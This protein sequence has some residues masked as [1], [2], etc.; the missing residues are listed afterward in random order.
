M[1]IVVRDVFQVKYGRGSEMVALLKEFAALSGK[2]YPNRIMSDASGPFFT[3]VQ[4]MEVPS[5]AEWEQVSQRV[6]SS[7]EFEPL[8]SRWLTLVNSGHREFYN[9]EP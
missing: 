9:L 4:E 8:F 2:N 6:F 3:I 1:V 5:L 7:K